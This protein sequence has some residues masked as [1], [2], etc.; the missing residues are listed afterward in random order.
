MSGEDQDKQAGDFYDPKDF[1]EPIPQ[2]PTATTTMMTQN[3]SVVSEMPHS[4]C[5][6]FANP[7]SPS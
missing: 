4:Y 7:A 3:T 5:N 1:L 2:E 6:R